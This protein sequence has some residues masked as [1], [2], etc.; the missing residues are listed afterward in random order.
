MAPKTKAKGRPKGTGKKATGKKMEKKKPAKLLTKKSVTKRNTKKVQKHEEASEDESAYTP[1]KDE[2]LSESEEDDVDVASNNDDELI[3]FEEED[4]P[5]LMDTKVPAVSPW[6]RV[7]HGGTTQVT[8]DKNMKTMTDLTADDEKTY[9]IIN[10]VDGTNMKYETEEE[11][12]E[13]MDITKEFDTALFHQL[14]LQP[15]TSD[16][17]MQRYL[18]FIKTMTPKKPPLAS[19]PWRPHPASP[20]A[21]IPHQNAKVV[22]EKP[23]KRVTSRKKQVVSALPKPAFSKH[24]SRSTEV[25]SVPVKPVAGTIPKLKFLKDKEKGGD[26]KTESMKRFEDA[27]K[28]GNTKLELWHLELQ[29]ADFD[30]WGF[31]LKDGAVDYWSWKPSLVEKAID[32]EQTTPLFSEEGTDMDTMLGYVRAGPI[33]ETPCG[34]NVI[35]A[36]TLKSGA[37]MERMT[38]VSL[39][40][41]PNTENSIKLAA[42]HLVDQFKN[43]KIQ[44]A[45][46]VTIT[47][48]MR[49]KIII[50]DCQ[51]GSGPLWG[52][53]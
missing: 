25:A 50:D 35:S 31:N 34:A 30:V 22:P 10:K 14:V 33:R 41:S 26:V 38:L 3:E 39:T 18:Q 32:A 6:A 37:R 52:K 44:E 49:A 27:M 7:A 8:P 1:S 16:S 51:P 48:N 36:I 29:G 24:D 20:I 21:T 45:Y 19:I 9:Y 11:A 15:F 28:H 23:S 47:T 5:S 42:K 46:F 53:L 40:P 2:A 43:I 4:T 13:F 17:Q 12:Q